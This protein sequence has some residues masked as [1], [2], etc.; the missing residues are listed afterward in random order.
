ML[1]HS[2]IVLLNDI[3]ALSDERA[4]FKTK[5][6]NNYTFILGSGVQ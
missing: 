6:S 3:T 1:P 4:H 5:E 2:Y